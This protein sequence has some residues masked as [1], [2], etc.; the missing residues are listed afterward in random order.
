VGVSAGRANATRRVAAGPPS[1]IGSDGLPRLLRA[2]AETTGL[3][4]DLY[5]EKC[6]RRRLDVRLRLHRIGSYREYLRFLRTNPRE[7]EQ[8]VDSLTI[9][10]SRFFRNPESFGA[11]ERQVLP[12]LL[13]EAVE[14][15]VRI[16]SAGAAA[17]EEAYTLAILWERLASRRP[18]PPAVVLLATDVDAASLARGRAGLYDPASLAEVPHRDLGRYF[19]P[20]GGRFRVSLAIR[21]RVRFR[22]SDLTRPLRLRFQDLI[23]CRNVLIYFEKALQ[24]ALAESFFRA[25]RPGG[26]LM[27][28]KAE[29]LGGPARRLFQVVDARERLYRKPAGAALRADGSRLRIRTEGG[30]A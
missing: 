26:F 19:V 11:L 24:E 10:V 16:W 5:K 4:C 12:V 28:G 25:L 17:G 27:L 23:V 1:A 21:A 14:R 8:L 9:N 2:I 20:E 18:D 15:P 7:A 13:T 30:S 6:L 22:R 3:D 29:T